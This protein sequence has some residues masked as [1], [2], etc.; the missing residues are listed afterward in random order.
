[1]EGRERFP[2]LPPNATHYENSMVRPEALTCHNC[3]TRGLSLIAKLTER[4]TSIHC[5]LRPASL[6]WR[7]MAARASCP[8]SKASTNCLEMASPKPTLSLQPPQSQPWPPGW[9]SKEGEG[10]FTAAPKR[11]FI[12]GSLRISYLA[13]RSCCHHSRSYQ[14]LRDC[15]SWLKCTWLQQ[16]WW[17]GR[18]PSPDLL[19]KERL[20]LNFRHHIVS[21]VWWATLINHFPT[22]QSMQT[23]TKASRHLNPCFVILSYFFI[24]CKQRQWFV[25]LL[26][27][28]LVL[29]ALPLAT[30]AT[31]TIPKDDGCFN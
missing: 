16:S 22:G 5:T 27:N 9:K 6:L 20:Q 14:S 30:M 21:E 2:K 17:R 23:C 3:P 29:F 18:T 15:S 28:G 12:Y 24:S 7:F 19:S 1:M 13:G 31:V 8:V 25:G 4:I 11:H 26:W 10:Y